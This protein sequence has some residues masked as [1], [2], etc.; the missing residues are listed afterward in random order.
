MAETK[1]LNSVTRRK[2]QDCSKTERR[3]SGS[4]VGSHRRLR[5]IRTKTARHKTSF[6]PAAVGLINKA[7]D[8]HVTLT[9]IPP[10]H[11]KDMLN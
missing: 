6:F 10:P 1:P 7:R 3:G 9:F 11:L 5:A 8:P 4:F 2:L